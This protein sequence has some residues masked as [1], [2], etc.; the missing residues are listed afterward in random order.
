MPELGKQFAHLTVA[1]GLMPGQFKNSTNLD[2]LLAAF[3]GETHAVQELENVIFDLYSKRWLWIA[4]GAQLDGLGDI[5][6]EPRESADD[7]EYRSQLYLKILT[8][9]SQGEPERLIEAANRAA[10]PSAVHLIERPVAT[11]EIYLHGYTETK[12]IPRVERVAAGGVQIIVTG[13][14]T[15]NPFVFGVDKDGSGTGYGSELPYGD[16]WGET[17][18]AYVDEGGLFTEILY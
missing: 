8:N 9:V 18:A 2:A 11:A 5:L 14:T 7:E 4:E 12:W 16:G 15:T 17:G 6:D 1:R 10:S 3:V 13:S